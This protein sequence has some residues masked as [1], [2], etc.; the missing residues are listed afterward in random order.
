MINSA[1][2]LVSMVYLIFIKSLDS[3]LSECF[4]DERPAKGPQYILVVHNLPD[5]CLHVG[6]LILDLSTDLHDSAVLQRKDVLVVILSSSLYLEKVFCC[7]AQVS[8][9]S[10]E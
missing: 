6:D 3:F 1:L 10:N 2:S 8:I 9:E 4:G 5:H 7:D